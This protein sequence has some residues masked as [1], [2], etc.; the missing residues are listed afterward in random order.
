MARV[1]VGLHLISEAPLLWVGEVPPQPEL[2]I[3]DVLQS[4]RF[5][6][7]LQTM[8]SGKIRRHS[9]TGDLVHTKWLTCYTTY[10]L[11]ES[12]FAKPVPLQRL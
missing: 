3:K 4:Q 8:T 12:S 1:K 5:Q 6:S 9:K 11:C 2:K 7:E 10:L